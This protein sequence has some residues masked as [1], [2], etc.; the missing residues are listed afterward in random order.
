MTGEAPANLDPVRLDA[1][2]AGHGPGLGPLPS[3]AVSLADFADHADRRLDLQALHWQLEPALVRRAIGAFLISEMAQSFGYAFAALDF[4]GHACAGLQPGN[5]GF[6][7]SIRTGEFEGETFRHVCHDW[8]VPATPRAVHPLDAPLIGEI[9]EG[10][11][12]PVVETIASESHLGRNPLWR[13]VSDG[14]GMGYLH[15]GKELGSAEHGMARVE[16]IVRRNGSRLY[17]RQLHFLNIRIPAQEA[18]G[19]KDICEWFRVR[20]GCCRYH[21]VEGRDYCG[22]CVLRNDHEARF[23]AFVLASAARR[24]RRNPHDLPCE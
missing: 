6:S 13:L 12:A 5:V 17:N 14:L 22:T 23:R 20:G 4:M 2:W 7:A 9:V 8:T 21:T 1:V 24:C 16:Q 19:G 11:F 18:P 3:N 10:L 15:V